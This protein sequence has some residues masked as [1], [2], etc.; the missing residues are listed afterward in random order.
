LE[1]PPSDIKKRR[2]ANGFW[3]IRHS[4]AAKADIGVMI[5]GN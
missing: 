5:P 1:L 2:F 3:P 4:Y